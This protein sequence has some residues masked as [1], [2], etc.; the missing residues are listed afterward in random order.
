MS[1]PNYLAKIKSAGI[2]RFVWDKSTIPPAS[3]ETLRLVVGYS[4]K[5]PF[6]TPVYI[7]KVSDF[8][9]IFGNVNK[10]LERKGIYFHRMAIQALAGGPILAL[11]LK[12]FTD[13]DSVKPEDADQVEKIQYL[14]VNPANIL[15][16]KTVVP[17]ETELTDV[18]NTNRFWY[19]DADQ[20]PEKIENTKY[21]T[22]AHTDTKDR[23][24]SLI[25]RPSNPSGYNVTIR[26]W[27]KSVLNEELPA[28]LEPIQHELVSKYFADVFVFRGEFT[29]EL[30][31]E[32][33]SFGNYVTEFTTDGTVSGQKWNGYFNINYQ[34]SK[35]ADLLYTNPPLNDFEGEN[36]DGEKKIVWANVANT[37]AVFP[38]GAIN[39]YGEIISSETPAYE[40]GARTPKGESGYSLTKTANSLVIIEDLKG[41]V[42]NITIGKESGG[43]MPSMHVSYELVA[44]TVFAEGSI[45]SLEESI[46]NKK[47]YLWVS[48]GDYIA[49]TSINTTKYAV[50]SIDDVDDNVVTKS[51]DWQ[52]ANS[53]NTD[54]ILEKWV[55]CENNYTLGKP[56][57]TINTEYQDAYGEKIDALSA[58]A[59]DTTSNF[60]QS[61]RGCLLP[62]FKD[63]MGN[64][65][66]LDII[67]NLDH[68]SHNMLMKIDE[69]VLDKILNDNN[70]ASVASVKEKLENVL[71]CQDVY[72]ETYIYE[73]VE[74]L[75]DTEKE[76]WGT[77]YDSIPDL[78]EKTA[79]ELSELMNDEAYNK[80]KVNNIC[81]KLVHKVPEYNVL[82]QKAEK[83]YLTPIYVQG[84]TY[85]TIKPN[86]NGITLQNKI[87]SV[88]E[89]KGIRTAL[90]NRVDVD[91]HYIVDTF[92]SYIFSNCKSKI[93]MIA[94][95]KD[96]AFALLNFP[97]M[98]DFIN[99]N[100]FKSNKKFDISKLA[101]ARY[102]FSLPSE[103]EGASYCAFFTNVAFSDGTL[104]SVVPSAA[105]VSNN[106]IKKYDGSLKPY[107]IIAGPNRGVIAYSGMIGPDYN[108]G[109]SDLDVLE[110]MGVNAIIYVPRKGVY[111]NSNQTA[112]QSP[113]SALSKIHIRELVIYI[114]D[115]IENM[116][117]NYQ[118]ELNTQTLRDAIKT[119]ADY[120]LSKIM[121]DG[122]IY[123]FSTV[124][125]STNNTP[126]IIDNEMLVLDIAIEPARGAGK[127]VQQLTIHKT[128][129]I[130]S[131]ANA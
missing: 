34:G 12:P 25:M 96:N 54:S 68:D 119:S 104:K 32:G 103:N 8:Y 78:S 45:N 94:K 51:S 1:L 29:P 105:I 82:G 13:K 38:A 58:L 61:Y 30:V 84:Y 39:R 40:W 112:K 110:P 20:L 117:Q 46:A 70:S 22:I 108:Y 21:L 91:Y 17:Q 67:F 107:S 44:E 52:I 118:W 116:L 48:G 10:K 92:K 125:D 42:P 101:S 113:V 81:Y 3:A 73:D 131:T 28:Y 77:E 87:L 5:G 75:T 106:F 121:S 9:T 71:Y 2:Y 93:S 55:A 124:C 79:E 102:G 64:Y 36:I 63:S 122:G 123:A 56:L 65:I 72:Q 50:V 27:Y 11:N 62:Y 69:T 33:G 95:E 37:E 4:E 15:R 109:R 6:N 57:I 111:I 35:D 18:Y 88:L 126:E 19:L 74:G 97:P 53:N 60:I 31:R 127:M 86:E 98:A 24:C 14:S 16:H 89:D 43:D 23:S 83:I 120:M 59:S 128:G 90:T 129:G 47:C 66:S 130:T 99:S 85:N 7:D 41:L 49:T 115:E 26:E 76:N 114:Q 100:K 80:I